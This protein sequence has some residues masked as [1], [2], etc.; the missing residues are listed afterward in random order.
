MKNFGRVLTAMITP[1]NA[2][3][4]VNY[5]AAAEVAK[6]LVAN[7]NDGLVVA[8]STGESATMSAEEKLRLFSTVLDAVG[9]RATV[10]AG[11]GSND[12][13]ASIKMTQDAE[14]L[15]VHG[16]MLVGPY[17]NKPPQEGFYQ[18]F[19]MIA[20]ETKLPIIL[21]NVPGR[22]ASNILPPTIARLS[23]IPNIVAVKEAS[24]SL[25][26]VSEIV[27]TARPGFQVYSGDDGL[28]LPVL[29]VG[30]C[31]VI[32]VAGHVVAARM[33]EMIAAYFTG[34]VKKAQSIHIQLMPFFKVIFVT[35]NPIPIKAAVNLM[36]LPGGELRPPMVPPT[37]SEI[38]Q[39]KTVMRS[40]HINV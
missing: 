5:E 14:K 27:R 19:K 13:L 10:I 9:D 26:Q 16:A 33:Q 3:Y 6:H 38:E 21:Y 4:S 11:T 23:E 1:F 15:G 29:S 22:T 12:T 8:G 24:G 34:D 25:E 18:H 2:D 20:T 30:G 37:Q 35:T 36:G 7:G 31:G 40:L 28:T 32:S 39:L 17:Y